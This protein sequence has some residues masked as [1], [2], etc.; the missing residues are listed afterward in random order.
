MLINNE[1]MVKG[2]SGTDVEGKVNYG[3]NDAREME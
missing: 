2:F 1:G 3:G